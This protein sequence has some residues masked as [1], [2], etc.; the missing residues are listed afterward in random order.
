ML[1]ERT[2]FP[3]YHIGESL[4]PAVEPLFEFLG[5]AAEMAGAEFVR[6]PGHTFRW[7]GDERTSYFGADPAGNDLLGY[8]VWRERFDAILLAR[9]RALGARPYLQ[10]NALGPMLDADGAV[11]GLYATGADG[12]PRSIRAR[13]VIDATGVRGLLAMRLRL[14]VRD[15]SPRSLAIWGYW[16]GAGDPPGKDAPN[17]YV[18][19]FADGWIWTVRVTPA[20]RNVTVMVDLVAER[21]RL[22]ALGLPGLYAE[23][24]AAT[25]A[26]RRFLARRRPRHPA[27]H[28][29]RQLVP[30][31]GRGRRGLPGDRRRGEHHRPLDL[32]GRAEGAQLGH[33]RRGRGQHH[34]PRA[35]AGCHRARLRP[36]GGGAHLRCL[37]GRRR[38]LADRRGALAEAALLAAAK[39]ARP[40]GARPRLPPPPRGGLKEAARHAPLARLRLAWAPGARL[41]QKPVVVRNILRL[42]PALVTTAVPA[43]IASPDLDLERLFPLVAARK[44]LPE[45][46]DG[47]LA[48]LGRGREARAE[49]LAAL[50]RLVDDGA[51]AVFIDGAI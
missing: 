35:G 34:P 5:V 51:L 22:R 44:P 7:N 50:E 25:T 40:R 6:M 20:L 3:R 30:R 45:V 47:Y 41:G 12:S 4:T 18:E 31:P 36:G 42:T 38:A 2:A 27:S 37:P 1:L 16:R 48:T 46:V 11:T 43:G 33:A 14:R 32:T 17:T 9:A 49:V 24:I 28:L 19:S 8:Q 29:R 23:A 26:T 15:P 10:T 13:L 39:R 21:P